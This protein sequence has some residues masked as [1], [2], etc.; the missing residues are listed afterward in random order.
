MHLE[1]ARDDRPR[2]RVL[3]I[4]DDAR[5]RRIIAMNLAVRGH[6]VQ[7]A[8]DVAHGMDA[9]ADAVPDLMI[10]GVN[11][12]GGTGWD[13]FRSAALPAAVRTVVVT[14]ASVDPRL[15]AEFHQLTYLPKPFPLGALLRLVEGASGGTETRRASSR[16]D[17]R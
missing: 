9:L 5:L 15:V 17:V 16:D 3:V 10:L 6:A 8:G 1:Q 7:E 11:L 4:E 14:A 2:S 13:E 12:P